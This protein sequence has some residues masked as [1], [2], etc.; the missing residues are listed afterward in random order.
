MVEL[1][2]KISHFTPIGTKINPHYFVEKTEYPFGSIQP[3]FSFDVP[4]NSNEKKTSLKFTIKTNMNYIQKAMEM[5]KKR[6]KSMETEEIAKNI[7]YNSLLHKSED[8]SNL[9]PGYYESSND[10]IA[11]KIKKYNQRKRE[12]VNIENI[13]LKRKNSSDVCFNSS[14]QSRFGENQRTRSLATPNKVDKTMKKKKVKVIVKENEKNFS[15]EKK[16]DEINISFC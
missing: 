15:G 2:K 12:K 8:T 3:R 7:K 1:E 5:S 6:S 9:G 11:E 16:E 14:N 4:K 10:T 13:Y